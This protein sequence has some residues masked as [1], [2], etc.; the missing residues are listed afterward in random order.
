MANV[1]YKYKSS[2]LKTNLCKKI[3]IIDKK[4]YTNSLDGIISDYALDSEYF[5]LLMEYSYKDI[6]EAR[7]INK[8]S[9]QRIKRL[10]DKIDNMISS[11]PCVWCTLTFRND[12][13]ESTNEDT[14][15]Q[16]VR[17][18]LKCLKCAYIANI[19]Y[20][21]TTEREHYHALV[22]IERI[23]KGSWAYGFDSYEKVRV[24]QS[25]SSIK[26]SKYISKLTNHYIKESTKRCAIIFS[27]SSGA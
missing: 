14:R 12:V 20:G 26:I 24:Q 8:A 6:N 21:T 13:L 11:G 9:Y 23:M 1:D 10:R 3:N 25:T 18:F 7:K 15:K 2:I 17:K 16:Y 19:D 22:S 4:T 5:D 27:R